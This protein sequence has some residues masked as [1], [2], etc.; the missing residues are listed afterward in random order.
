MMKEGL[1]M[2]TAKS[3]PAR[4]DLNYL[5]KL[6]K[7]RLREMRKRQPAAR[8]AQTQLAIARE[9]GFASWRKLKA[10]VE[11]VRADSDSSGLGESQIAEFSEALR[12]KDHAAIRRLLKQTPALATAAE[13]YGQTMLHLAAELNDTHSIEMLI[14]AGARTDAKWYGHTPL[15]W[16]ATVGMP[17]AGKALARHGVEAD[18]FCAAGFGDLKRVK[19]FFDA[20]G[21]LLPNASQTGSS[22]HTA[23][24]KRLPCPPTKDSEIVADALYVAVRHGHANVARFV[25]A[26]RPDLS[27]RAYMRGTLLHWAYFGANPEIIQMLL[28]AGANQTDNDNFYQCTP[29]GFGIHVASDWGILR[30]VRRQLKNEPELANFFDGGTTPLHRAAAKNHAAIVRWLLR[31]GADPNARD[32]N[33]KTALEIAKEKGHEQVVV[34]IENER[35]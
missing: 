32:S 2:P 21:Q 6:A 29:R 16:A 12:K 5:K 28:D 22:R 17:N 15:S 35:N 26:H 10:H 27:F 20:D 4:P 31:T 34:A 24:R 1:V 23:D 11:Q 13:P 3:L 25:L 18:L 9:Y 14:A 8:L 19:K 7:E 30:Q 33:G